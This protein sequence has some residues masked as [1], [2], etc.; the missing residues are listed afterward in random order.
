MLKKATHNTAFH[1]HADAV[2]L[3]TVNI[4]CGTKPWTI[5]V[6]VNKN[7]NHLL[8]TKHRADVSVI[9]SGDHTRLGC[10]LLNLDKMLYG[11]DNACI[12]VPGVFSVALVYKYRSAEAKVYIVRHVSMPLLG[13][14][15]ISMLNIIVKVDSVIDAQQQIITQYLQLFT[16]LGCKRDP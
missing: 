1:N 16:R 13:R 3:D 6:K 5:E 7:C 8:Q 12:D 14:D 2:F 15:V 11:S 9:S 10:K 4:T